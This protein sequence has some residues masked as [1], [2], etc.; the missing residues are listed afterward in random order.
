MVHSIRRNR[1]ETANQEKAIAELQTQNPQLKNK[2]KF[3]K[4]AGK[5]KTMMSR[6]PYRPLLID[7]GT[8]DKAYIIVE[9]GLLHDK[10]PKKCDI[11]FSECNITQCYKCQ[12]YGHIAVTCGKPQTRAYCA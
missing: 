4:L 12:G 1:V 7:I 3:L 11:F 5:T 8:L 9:K 10:E 6:K 2:L